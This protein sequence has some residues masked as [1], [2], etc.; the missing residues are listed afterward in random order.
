MVVFAIL[1]AEG[2]IDCFS[3][4]GNNVIECLLNGFDDS[5][6][7][8]RIYDNIVSEAPETESEAKL[9]AII[10]SATMK[11]YYNLLLFDITDPK[12][13]KPINTDIVKDKNVDTN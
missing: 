4:I 6:E 3:G 1:Q 11:E 12:N 13:T 7:L 10:M 2:N 5:I 8:K 9:L